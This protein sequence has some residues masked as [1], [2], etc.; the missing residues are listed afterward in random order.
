VLSSTSAIFGT[1]GWEDRVREP[2]IHNTSSE[3]VSLEIC[4]RLFC[5]T[6]KAPNQL[7]ERLQSYGLLGGTRTYGTTNHCLTDEYHTFTNGTVQTLRTW[8]PVSASYAGLTISGG[9]TECTLSGASIVCRLNG[10]GAATRTIKLPPGSW[11]P[12]GPVRSL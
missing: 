3:P 7:A 11:S 8:G 9:P 10:M 1:R 4:R 12:D 5:L 6:P 2:V